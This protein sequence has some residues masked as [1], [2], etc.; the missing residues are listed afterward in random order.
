LSP[1]EE[2]KYNII[3]KLGLTDDNFN[4]DLA[5]TDGSDF[6]LMLPGPSGGVLKMWVAH[7]SYSHKCA[8][9]FFCLPFLASKNFVTFTAYWGNS[10]AEDISDPGALGFLFYESFSDTSL[11]PLK[12]SGYL[13]GGGYE[14]GHRLS[15]KFV[16]LTNPLQNVNSWVVD[17]GIYTDYQI[18]GN[19]IPGMNFWLEGTENDFRIGV[20]DSDRIRHNVVEPGGSTFSYI[21]KP[22][23]GMEGPNSYQEIC[24]GYYEPEDRVIVKLLH[25]DTFPDVDY[26][27]YRKV[28]GDTRPINVGLSGRDSNGVYYV[29]VSWLVVREY[30]SESISDLDGSF[31]YIQYESVLPQPQDFRRFSPDFTSIGYHHES[32]FGGNPYLL[33][34]NG[35]ED[36]VDAWVSDVD[37]I[38]EVQVDLTIHIGWMY[39]LTSKYYKHY[40][41]GHVYYY[42][43]SKLSDNDADKMERNFWYCTTTSGWAAIKFPNPVEVGAI[44]VK[45]NSNLD[46]F[47]E[48]FI[49]YGS[50][51]NP[52][53][54]FS[55]ATEIV[56]GSFVRTATWQH[57]FVKHSAPY[58]Y[59]ILSVSGT[60]NN[61]PIRIQEWEMPGRSDVYR[62]KYVSQLK[63]HPS[64]CG[65]WQQNF[66]KEISLLGTNDGVNWESI[67]PW[68]GTYT[69]FIQHYA[70]DGYWQRYFIRNPKGFWS[71][72]LSCR[73][74]WGGQDG[75]III[76]EWSL[77][78]SYDDS[79]TNKVLLGATNNI[80][81]IWASSGCGISSSDGTIY[82][83]ND[84]MNVVSNN[85]LSASYTIEDEYEDFNVV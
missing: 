78:E 40:D 19:T 3:L 49:F 71:F 65:D 36:C 75:R 14:Y 61:E 80:Q 10:V 69:P 52:V 23:G 56:S 83:S 81:Q 11:D 29:Y 13:S 22:Y 58:R 32:S 85:D 72:K 20:S 60:L 39:N 15:S 57:S 51:Y 82:I 53:S 41:S 24:V 38:S 73:G 9:L 77:H 4:F 17:V 68:T 45:A 76:G 16:T 26:D 42:N 30:D 66:P 5:N 67:L 34:N 21:I 1:F 59:Y 27:I 28:E 31:L 79:H 62:K 18:P 6:R 63:L 8:T 47:P 55:E 46:A 35:Y 64:L 43:A 70:G 74:N 33:S 7:W 50:N 37:A 12:W 25:R 2:D 84:I 48:Y 44:R 54:C